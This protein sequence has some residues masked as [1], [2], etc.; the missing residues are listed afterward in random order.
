MAERALRADARRN[1]ERVLEAAQELFAQQGSGVPLDEIAARAGVGPGTVYRHFP[2]KEALFAAVTEARLRDLVDHAR[3]GARADD[4]GAAFGGFLDRMAGEA[5]ARRNLQ[6]VF[7]GAGPEGLAP[8][9]QEMYAALEV[10][11]DR[12]QRAGAVRAGITVP[13]LVALLKAM[14]QVAAESADPG[15]LERIGAV[16]RDGLRPPN[17]RRIDLSTDPGAAASS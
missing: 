6:E 14:A 15:T 7:A 2:T 4:P 17:G 5:V 1:R 10:L 8:V 11:L 16:V 13:D 9:R 12:A 3:A